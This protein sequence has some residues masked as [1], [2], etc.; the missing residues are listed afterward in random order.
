MGA[1]F[2]RRLL[3]I[4]PTFLGITMLVFLITRFVPGGPIEQAIMQMQGATGA[5]E[6]GGT[7]GI[8]GSSVDMPPELLAQLKEHYHFDKN[9]FHAY[10]L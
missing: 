6:A 10:V 4:I 1:Y 5:G 2:A 7:S 3:L 9:P 8:G